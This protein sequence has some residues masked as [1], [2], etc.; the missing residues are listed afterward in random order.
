MCQKTVAPSGRFFQLSW[1][2]EGTRN[3]PAT[4]EACGVFQ[5]P[6]LDFRLSTGVETE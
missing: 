3:Y 5:G 6:L 2:G 4:L 1:G